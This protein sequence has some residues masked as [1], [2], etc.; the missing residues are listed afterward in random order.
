MLGNEAAKV[1]TKTSWILVSQNFSE[2]CFLNKNDKLAE[3][4]ERKEVWLSC[5]ERETKE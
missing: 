4:K 3:E 5:H 2:Y 1:T